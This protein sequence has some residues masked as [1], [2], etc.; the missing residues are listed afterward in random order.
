MRSFPFD[1]V[2]KSLYAHRILNKSGFSQPGQ[3]IRPRRQSSLRR[4]DA[5]RDLLSCNKNA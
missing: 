3:P 4:L 5:I 2:D 1:K